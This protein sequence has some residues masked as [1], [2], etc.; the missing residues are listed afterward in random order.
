MKLMARRHAFGGSTGNSRF[1][2][3]Y[4]NRQ[5]A[6]RGSLSTQATLL[7]SSLLHQP[8]DTIRVECPKRQ[9]RLS[10][11]DRRTPVQISQRPS[12]SANKQ[13][14][15][16]EYAAQPLATTKTG[17]HTRAVPRCA[18]EACAATR[19]WQWVRQHRPAAPQSKNF[20]ADAARRCTQNTP[21]GTGLRLR[22]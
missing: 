6:R 10:K 17:R 19:A 16:T 18:S 21:M 1:H 4:C 11:T 3:R 14:F 5:P 22:P 12:T 7:R 9:P 20:S 13:V 8:S 15:N 2:Q